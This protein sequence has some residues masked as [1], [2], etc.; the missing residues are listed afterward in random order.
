MK[1][2]RD[3]LLFFR[4]KMMETLRNPIYI[5]MSLLTPILYLVLFSPLLK[6][7]IN[8]PGMS[9]SGVMNIFVP[10]LLVIVAFLSG[11]FVGYVMIDEV[12]NGVVE[13]FRVTP[14]SRFALLAGR[15][16]RDLVNMLVIVNFF[17][18]IAIPFGFKIHFWG[19]LMLLLILCLILIT[20]SSFGNA[21][22]LILKDEDRLSPIVQGINL[23]ILLLSGML[24]PMELAPKW[25]QDI[26][27]INPAYYAVEAGRLLAAGQIWQA[28]VGYAF[29]FLVPLAALTVWWAT[30]AFNKAVA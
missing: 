18:V 29:L 15:V 2:L 21:L 25:L 24:L 26:A 1:T 3:T 6:K 12:R 27:H 20:T 28:K 14:T 23:P 8:V 4:R 16:L 10:G 9:S 30:R 22:G 5:V 7:I 19:Y 11:L 13:R 17:A